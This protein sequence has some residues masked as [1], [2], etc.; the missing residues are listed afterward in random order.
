MIPEITYLDVLSRDL[1]VMDFTAI[2][3]CRDYDLPIIVFNLN[4]RGNMRR[5]AMGERIGTLVSSRAHAAALALSQTPQ[6]A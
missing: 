5:I 2:T 6:E 3:M 4:Q 1:A